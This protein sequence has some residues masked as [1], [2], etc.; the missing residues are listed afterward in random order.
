MVV[1]EALT[2]ENLKREQVSACEEGVA[3]AGRGNMPGVGE[4][5]TPG[6]VLS[7]TAH[8]QGLKAIQAAPAS[9]APRALSSRPSS[10]RVSHRVARGLEAVSLDL[11]PSLKDATRSG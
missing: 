1:A 6:F 8:R 5:D 4:E 9:M 10:S 2:D 11:Q 3:G 7:N